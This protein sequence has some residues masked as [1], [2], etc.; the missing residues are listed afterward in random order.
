MEGQMSDNN[1]H[2]D[3]H[4]SDDIGALFTG[5]KRGLGHPGAQPPNQIHESLNRITEKA[6]TRRFALFD[7]EE[8]AD[9]LRYEDLYNSPLFALLKEERFDKVRES[10]EDG[11]HVKRVSYCRAVDYTELNLEKLFDALIYAVTG[12]GLPLPLGIKVIETY[13]DKSDVEVRAEALLRHRDSVAADLL[14]IKKDIEERKVKANKAKD[15]AK[16]K[17]TKKKDAIIDKKK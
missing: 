2:P 11:A 5:S 14:K 17:K 8:E 10:T 12:E 7:M 1:D 13:F 9:V 4:D 3:F 16:K 15:K 6:S